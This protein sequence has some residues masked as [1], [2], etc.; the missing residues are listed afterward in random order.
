[1]QEEELLAH[2]AE[3]LQREDPLE[4]GVLL[5][6]LEEWDSLAIVS[7]MALYDN[8]FGLVITGTALRN[9][10]SVGDLLALAKGGGLD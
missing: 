9:C 5:D 6:S 2:I 10:K 3:A 8:L 7:L 1:M 4:P